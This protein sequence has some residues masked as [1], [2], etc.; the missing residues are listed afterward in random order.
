M[1]FCLLLLGLKLVQLHDQLPLF[2]ASCSMPH[3]AC[4]IL[5][6]IFKPILFYFSVL[7]KF[8][9]TLDA[10]R[11]MNAEDD[12]VEVR[13]CAQYVMIIISLSFFISMIY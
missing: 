5:A 3:A 4:L 12:E 7:P 13:L 9:V 11:M 6:V 10:P 2:I 8:E 1:C